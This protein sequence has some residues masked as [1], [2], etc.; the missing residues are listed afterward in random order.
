MLRNT[1]FSSH[2]YNAV[3][4]ATIPYIVKIRRCFIKGDTSQ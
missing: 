4:L 2:H 1:Y 3:F